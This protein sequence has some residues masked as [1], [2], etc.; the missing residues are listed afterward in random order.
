[1]ARDIVAGILP[2]AVVRPPNIRVAF[3]QVVL[4]DKAIQERINRL[5][6][7]LV[8]NMML[9]QGANDPNLAEMVGTY[10]IGLNEK[11]LL[12]IY[13]ENFAIMRMAAHGTTIADSLTV[14]LNTGEVYR[15][16]D[17]FIRIRPYRIR[18]NNIIL[19]K[20]AA[21]NLPTIAPFPGI[22]DSQEFYLTSKALV[23]FFPELEFTPHYVGIPEFVIPYAVLRK[24][25]NPHGPLARLVT[26]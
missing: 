7:D 10:K 18:I 23:I 3:P 13:F 22:T 24:M 20:I 15:L 4:P 2:E 21:T 14:D 6:R 5:I 16:N 12:S 19:A 25:I 26:K 8:D 17:L 1:M 9:R 11:S